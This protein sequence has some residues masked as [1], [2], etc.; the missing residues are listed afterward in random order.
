MNQDNKQNFEEAFKIQKAFT[1]KLFKEKY[2]KNIAN[3]TRDERLRWSKE[4]IL[5]SAKEI[6][7]MLD[8]LNWKTHRYINK[9]DSMDNF[10]EEGIDAFKFLL[11]LFIING[12]DADYFYTKFL[13]KSIVVDIRYEQEKQLKEAKSSSRV[14]VAFDID[15]ILNDYPLNFIR[16]F[17]YLGFDYKSIDEFKSIDIVSYTAVKKKFRMA[18]E[19]RNCKP[20]MPGIELL[21]K[22]QDSG[23]GIILLTARPFNKITRLF[24]DTI[25]WLKDNEIH[26]D[27]LFFA[28]E[29]EEYLINN[30]NKE[31][32]KCVIDDQ[33]DNANKL[34]KFFETYL[35]FNNA[36]YEEDDLRYAN[37]IIN[38]VKDINQIQL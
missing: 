26:Y 18:G 6:F 11:N 37:K 19:E 34:C 5:S 25:Q 36:L 23:Y 12:F 10:A 9:E 20:N 21:K 22:A 31:S 17:N 35:V 24:F 3:F 29:K 7:E 4:Y 28:E 2:D 16:Y 30:F 13:E 14:Y 8:E 32:I 33:I 1:E 15:G 38:V 27:F